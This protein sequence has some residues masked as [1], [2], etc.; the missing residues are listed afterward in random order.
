M[1]QGSL[2]CTHLPV[3]SGHTRSGAAAR[4]D[5]VQKSN[6]IS[7]GSWVTVRDISRYSLPKSAIMLGTFELCQDAALCGRMLTAPG[8]Q[9]VHLSIRV[10]FWPLKYDGLQTRS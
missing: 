10:L 2:H 1:P 8:Q 9:T 4:E 3:Q 7:S 6:L 5:E